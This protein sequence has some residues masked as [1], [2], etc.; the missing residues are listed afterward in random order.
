VRQRRLQLQRHGISLISQDTLTDPARILVVDDEATIR[1]FLS[2]L[3]T[4]E[5]MLVTC[6]SDGEGALEVLGTQ[7]F[8]V[9]LSDL[10]MTGLDGLGLLKSFSDRGFVATTVLMTGFGTVDTAVE[11]MK[12][13]AHDYILK[14]FTPE[15][16]LDVLHRALAQHRL[17]QENFELRESIGFFELSQA[18]ASTLPLAEQLRLIADLVR[19]NFE[20]AGVAIWLCD[21]DT[22]SCQHRSGPT[23]F[24][25]R[26]ERLLETFSQHGLVRSNGAEVTRWLERPVQAGIVCHAFMSAP[27]H[28][29]GHPCGMINCYGIRSRQRFS[30]GQRKGLSILAGR[31]ASAIDLDRVYRQLGDTFTDTIEGFARVLE[32]KDPYTHGHSD[33]V[34]TYARAIAETLGLAKD[35]C[36]RIQHGGLLHDIGKVGVRSEKLNKPQRLSVQEYRLFQSHPVK[37]RHI[38]EPISFLVHVIPCVYHHHETWDACGYPEGLGG[39]DIPEDARILAV[40]DTY[41]AMTS[42]RPYR[43]ALPH[44]IAID[45]LR[46]CSGRQFD[47]RVVEA[48]LDG[49]RPA[50]ARAATA[51]DGTPPA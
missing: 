47:P 35:A 45:E 6:R 14:P 32:A 37:G 1:E 33:R 27:M 48:F 44:D 46:R 18:L 2:D 42:D 16:L 5:G 9:V 40:A 38:I 11:A 43:K 22:W 17:R 31:S 7:D 24:G 8:E 28:S 50:P 19:S 10:K 34:A 3:L 26:H 23:D 20:A 36:L 21:G 49:V 51:E 41:D 25:A 13:G 30:E 4:A 12:H 15:K 29:R 39:H